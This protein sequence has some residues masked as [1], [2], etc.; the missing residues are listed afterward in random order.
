MYPEDS[1][2]YLPRLHITTIMEISMF[3]HFTRV[4][5]FTL[6]VKTERDFMGCHRIEW[7][8]A[9]T[10]FHRSFHISTKV[11]YNLGWWRPC[12]H[13][14]DIRVCSISFSFW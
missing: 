9:E 4:Q 12:S 14:A 1:G 3:S 5:P 2:T 6:T 13:A 10:L 11:C 7:V 8:P